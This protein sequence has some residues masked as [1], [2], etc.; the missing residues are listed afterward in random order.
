[1]FR[2]LIA[3]GKEK[4]LYASTVLL[5][6]GMLFSSC[7]KCKDSKSDFPAEKQENGKVWVLTDWNDKTCQPIYEEKPGNPVDP[8]KGVKDQRDGAENAYNNNANACLGTHVPACMNDPTYGKSYKGKFDSKLPLV[9]G[10]TGTR[11]DSLNAAEYANVSLQALPACETLPESFKTNVITAGSRATDA[12][13]NFDFWNQ[14]IKDVAT[15][16]QNNK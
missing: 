10:N 14:Y 12:L 1:M 7:G 2:N 9:E 16:E 5:A 3:I 11:L 13:T 4:A 6:F 15:C 8:C